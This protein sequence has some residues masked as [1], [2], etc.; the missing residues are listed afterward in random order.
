MDVTP[1][2]AHP[3][4]ADSDIPAWARLARAAQR[5]LPRTV[6]LT[7]PA[8]RGP[9]QVT[10]TLRVER[11]HLA[12]VLPLNSAF[13]VLDRDGVTA[14][15]DGTGRPAEGV[16]VELYGR[17]AYIGFPEGGFEASTVPGVTLGQVW[18]G[19]EHAAVR[20]V[21]ELREAAETLASCLATTGTAAEA[22]R[23]RAREAVLSLATTHPNLTG[24]QAALARAL[25]ARWTSR[26]AALV[27]AAQAVS[28]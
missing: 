22:V 4:P 14:T 2:L 8:P 3:A 26:P 28:V 27:R 25:A 10:A 1:L 6:H 7:L 21:M 17:G 19:P 18:S 13:Y 5:L 12:T 9:R 24:E 11:L 16:T 15:L 20:A 23:T